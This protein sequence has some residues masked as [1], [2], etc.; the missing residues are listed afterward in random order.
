M[1]IIKKSLSVFALLSCLQAGYAW[2]EDVPVLTNAD[3]E[4]LTA[5]K[6]AKSQEEYED[7]I[8]RVSFSPAPEGRPAPSVMQT[9][10]ELNL[11]AKY[12]MVFDQNKNQVVYSKNPNYRVPIASVTKLMSAMVLLDGGQDMSEIISIGDDDVDRLKGSSS[13]LKVGAGLT[14]YEMLRL[15]VMSSENRATHAL[16]RSYPGGVEAFV[17]RMNRKAASLGMTN[18]QF[19]DPTGLSSN[20]Q[21]TPADLVKMVAAARGYQFL[22]EIANTT[23]A[24]VLPFGMQSVLSYVNSNRL[25]RTGRWNIGISKTGHIREAGNCLVLQADIANNPYVIVILNAPSTQARFTDADRIKTWLESKQGVVF[26]A[27]Q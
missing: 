12:V 18:T 22:N 11:N 14:R 24:D 25:L 16:A 17:A 3:V 5:I 15:S 10:Q 13:R 19:Q 7:L 23:G 4:K 26:S 9:A 1:K 20:N 2:A 8:R 21:S 6:Q 27:L